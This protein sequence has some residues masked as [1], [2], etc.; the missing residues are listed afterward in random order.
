M[1]GV[2][3]VTH[4]PLAAELLRAAEKIAGEQPHFRALALEWS[5]GLE[6]SRRRIGDEIAAL[7]A[8]HGV[9]VLTDM[10]GDTPSNAALGL[11]EPGK[12]EMLSGVNLPMVVRL[13]CSRTSRRPLAELARW[14]EVKG[15]RSIRRAA[16]VE[17]GPLPSEGTEGG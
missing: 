7:D 16:A 14:L 15:R 11:F 12:V 8:G 10:F 6:E 9:L 3:I 13:A 17:R 2:L 1:I 5:E 4:G